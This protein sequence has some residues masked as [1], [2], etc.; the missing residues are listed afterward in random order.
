MKSMRGGFPKEPK[1][2]K[3]LQKYSGMTNE[4]NTQ[5]KKYSRN[6]LLKIIAITW[7]LSLITALV[8]VNFAG[9]FQQKSWHR[10]EVYKGTFYGST[11]IPDFFYFEPRINSDIW[12]ISWRVSTDEN[13]PPEDVLFYFRLSGTPDTNILNQEYPRNFV[14]KE[15][16]RS[17]RGGGYKKSEAGVEHFFGSGKP[18]LTIQGVKLDWRIIIEEYY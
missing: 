17:D 5:T 15:D 14:T 11:E 4:S 6:Q 9:I 12:R 10:I 1:I 3:K 7:I 8:V 13:P 16:F 18:T 2:P